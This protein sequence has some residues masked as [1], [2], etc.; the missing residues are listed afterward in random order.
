M[1]NKTFQN[2]I[3]VF[4]SEFETISTFDFKNPNSRNDTIY[5][6]QINIYSNPGDSFDEDSF[7]KI[8]F[9]I[10]E[11]IKYN[12]NLYLIINSALKDIY[13][14]NFH[15]LNNWLLENQIDLKKCFFIHLTIELRVFQSDKRI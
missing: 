5:F 1:N 14:I 9:K 4:E 6:Y 7:N 12:P 13:H 15:N 8:P 11:H 3:S 10:I 2:N